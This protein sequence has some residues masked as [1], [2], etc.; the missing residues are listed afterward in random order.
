MARLPLWGR[1]YRTIIGAY[2]YHRFFSLG[3][4][5]GCCARGGPTSSWDGSREHRGSSPAKP[6]LWRSLAWA[7]IRFTSKTCAILIA[8]LPTHLALPSAVTA[9]VGWARPELFLIFRAR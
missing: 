2:L 7:T 8:S 3:D 4:F 6:K 5:V 1:S 9:S